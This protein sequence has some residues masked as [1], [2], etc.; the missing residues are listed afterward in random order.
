MGVRRTAEANAST[1]ATESKV[2]RRIVEQGIAQFV[3][4]YKRQVSS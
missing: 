1:W 2:S 4:A 3:I